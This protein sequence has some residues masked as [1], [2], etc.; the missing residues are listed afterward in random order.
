MLQL[1]DKREESTMFNRIANLFRK[2]LP[3][4]KLNVLI[5]Q[6]DDEWIAHCLQ[7]DIVAT[8]GGKSS[9]MNDIVDLIKAQVEYAVDNDNLS[10][11]F[12]PAPAEE[13]EK[14]ARFQRCEVRKIIIDMP[15]VDKGSATIPIREVELCVA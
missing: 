15:K 11:I 10:S 12:R 6:E 1:R 14:L 7:M 9:V 5:Y 2:A 4:V 13:W 8:S 3:S